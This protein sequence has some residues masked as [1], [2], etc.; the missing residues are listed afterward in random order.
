[1]L[2]RLAVGFALALLGCGGAA[3]S[4]D[5]AVADLSMSV[6]AAVDLTPAC[7]PPSTDAGV[8]LDTVNGKMVD[9]TG[10][11]VPNLVVSVCA[12]ACYFGQTTAD[13]TFSNP[14]YDLVVPDYYAFEAHGRPD[15]AS[16][17][18]RLPPLVGM[19]ASYAQPLL[20]PSLPASGPLIALDQSAQTLTSGDVTLNLA[21]GTKV[22]LDVEDVALKDVGRQLRVVK[23]SPPS[24]LPFFDGQSEPDALYGFAPF[25]VFF[26]QPTPL[27]FANSA[28]LPANAAVDV[29]EMGGLI[30][31]NPPA[32]NFTKVATAHVS[33]DGNTIV[34]D[35]GQ[36]VTELTWI[37][38]RKQ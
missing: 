11:G 22:M 23:I 10:A 13:G 12:V 28:A 38:L 14:V 19:S 6:D 30:N 29:L 4:D 31:V 3:G 2:M 21:S 18:A 15:H 8:C 27:T 34:M 32:G 33:A 7:P 17:Y 1:M 25:E 24:K 37:A 20:L 16:W 35:S 26:S 5:A 36:G 9:D